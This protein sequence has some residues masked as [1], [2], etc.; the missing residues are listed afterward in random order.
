[1]AKRVIQTLV[2]IVNED[3]KLESIGADGVGQTGLHDLT[4]DIVTLP[5][6]Q[7]AFDSGSS[8][9]Q[10]TFQAAVSGGGYFPISHPWA[11][12][13]G[14][15]A[16]NDLGT[17]LV[18]GPLALTGTDN[19]SIVGG[20][21]QA[22][23][24]ADGV[25]V[26]TVDGVMLSPYTNTNGALNLVRLVRAGNRVMWFCTQPTHAHGIG[27]PDYIRFT[28]L[29]AVAESGDDQMGYSYTS[30]GTGWASSIAVA[31]RTISTGSSGSFTIRPIQAQTIMGLSQVAD[32]GYFGIWGVMANGIGSNYT[33]WQMGGTISSIAQQPG[34][35]L[36]F[37]RSAN[38]V[39]VISCTRANGSEIF[40]VS[41]SFMGQVWPCCA[42][43]GAGTSVGPVISLSGF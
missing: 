34:D 27:L 31:S 9:D 7:T 3:G 10:A 42:F 1:M 38:G 20:T 4:N 14:T 8:A 13:W 35:V 43:N 22:V 36:K 17:I 41:R 25:N 37:E 30:T 15:D 39:Y 2:G 18:S 32:P 26:P 24:V 23:L 11:T 21:T 6:I 33:N 28:S 5:D 29:T 40:L 12:V 19:E 16:N